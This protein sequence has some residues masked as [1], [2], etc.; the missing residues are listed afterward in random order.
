MGQSL[1]NRP[2]TIRDLENTM[3]TAKQK[4][5]QLQ[6]IFVIINRKGDPAYGKFPFTLKHTYI[7]VVVNKIFFVCQMLL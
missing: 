2:C 6:K 7:V 4:F 3:K 1:F 5:P